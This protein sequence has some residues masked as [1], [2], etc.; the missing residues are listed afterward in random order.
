MRRARRVKRVAVSFDA[1]AG[2]RLSSHRERRRRGTLR[3]RARGPAEQAPAARRGHLMAGRFRGHRRAG[4]NVAAAAQGRVAGH[5]GGLQGVHRAGLRKGNG[6]G[7]ERGGVQAAADAPLRRGADAARSIGGYHRHPPV[8]RRRRSRRRRC[9]RGRWRGRGR[10]LAPGD[11]GGRDRGVVLRARLPGRGRSQRGPHPRQG[12]KVAR[13]LRERGH[14]H[15][16]GRAERRSGDARGP[17]GQA[18]RGRH[19]RGLTLQGGRR[20]PVG[21]RERLRLLLQG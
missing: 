21:H 10:R 20:D 2:R 12:D 3:E 18:G 8:Q 6:S 14:R 16:Q 11:G 9:P 5:R 19:V 13:K 15:L 7:D 17:R 4:A 1:D